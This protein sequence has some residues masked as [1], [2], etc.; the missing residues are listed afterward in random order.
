MKPHREFLIFLND[1]YPGEAWPKDNCP[2]GGFCG[3]II[4]VIDYAAYEKTL[5]E[6]NEFKSQCAILVEKV[7]A[8]TA[9]VFELENSNKK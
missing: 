1:A 8:I 9:M 6:L 5:K 2:G 4:R 3:D 7:N